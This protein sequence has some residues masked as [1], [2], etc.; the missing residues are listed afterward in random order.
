MLIPVDDHDVGQ[1]MPLNLD[2]K[3]GWTWARSAVLGVTR[4]NRAATAGSGDPCCYAILENALSLDSAVE[5]AAAHYFTMQMAVDST[6][7]N[8]TPIALRHDG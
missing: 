4:A 7:E 5:A 6:G 2:W 1:F 8:A 3:S